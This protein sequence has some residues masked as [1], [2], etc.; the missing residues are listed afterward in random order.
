MTSPYEEGLVRFNCGKMN[1][2]FETEEAE[3]RKYF[4]T[5]TFTTPAAKR[6]IFSTS[7]FYIFL[8]FLLLFLF[9]FLEEKEVSVFF[10]CFS[11]FSLA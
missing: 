2:I 1:H 5:K 7:L 11:F 10:F 9:C 4:Y 6:K 8:K 3:K